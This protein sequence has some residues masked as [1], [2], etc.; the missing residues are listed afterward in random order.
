ML[1]DVFSQ[2]FSDEL[3]AELDQEQCEALVDAIAIAVYADFDASEDEELEAKLL[4]NDLPLAWENAEAAEHYLDQA[5]RRASRLPDHE[6]KDAI[7]DVAD[8]IP[9]EAWPKVYEFVAA[10]VYAD[11]DRNLD[12]DVVLRTF[13]TVLGLDDDVVEGIERDITRFFQ[14]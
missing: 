2:V 1:N 4:L 8:R 6:L 11:Q 10:V 9:A 5:M 12:E 3:L 7:V 13:Q 14:G